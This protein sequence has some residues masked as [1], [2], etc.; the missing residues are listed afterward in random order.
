[1]F[2][3]ALVSQDLLVVFARFPR[4]VGDHKKVPSVS[5]LL[6]IRNEEETIR[7]CLESLLDQDL[8]DQ[9][10]LVAND[11][12]T[13]N[14]SSILAE[15]SNHE[16]LTIVGDLQPVPEGINPK[17]W[18]LEHLSN[19]AKGEYI[20]VA[21]GDCRYPTGWITG[22]WNSMD[23][24]AVISGTTGIEGRG[25]EDLDWRL[26]I[27][28]MTLLNSWGFRTS[29]IGNNMLMKK[30]ILEEAG[31]WKS[32]WDHLTEDFAINERILDLGYRSKVIYSSEV[33]AISRPTPFL[34]RFNQRKR[35]MRGVRQ[36]HWTIQMALYGQSFILPAMVLFIIL[37][38]NWGLPSLV[39]YLVTKY[40]ADIRLLRSLGQMSALLLIPYQFYHLIWTFV[41]HAYFL[42]SGRVEWKGRKYN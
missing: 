20:A 21:D 32:V 23:H 7:A 24:A 36:L 27:G 42:V 3:L 9:E 40:F 12:S 28:R 33:A 25:F 22:L 15:F 38:P 4:H 39:L 29:A 16:R 2:T 5:I 17:A 10:V 34:N 14:T 19:M 26:N 35:W 6:V 13:D 18:H 37:S 8:D 41:F 31:G 30:E 1:M 11:F